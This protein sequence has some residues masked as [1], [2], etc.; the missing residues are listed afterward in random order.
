MLRLMIA[1]IQ[2]A[3]GI[4]CVCSL[5]VYC[6]TQVNTTLGD[7]H[8]SSLQPGDTTPSPLSFEDYKQGHPG[9]ALLGLNGIM[10]AP[11]FF[12]FLLWLTHND[13][14]LSHARRI[15]PP[16]SAIS[17]RLAQWQKLPHPLIKE[18][19]SW[20]MPGIK[21]WSCLLIGSIPTTA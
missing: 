1:I 4:C 18:V 20:F 6:H 3:Y 10:T 17:A 14:R 2:E 13:F 16:K 12:T 19:M 5:D 9:K 7:I 15:L 8:S 11:R 21:V